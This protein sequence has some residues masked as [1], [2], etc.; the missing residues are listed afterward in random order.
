[1]ATSDE[2][3]RFARECLALAE[4]ATDPMDRVRLLAMAQ[5]WRNLADKK[6]ANPTS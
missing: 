3:R 1:M 6:D 5:A 4:K 2:Y